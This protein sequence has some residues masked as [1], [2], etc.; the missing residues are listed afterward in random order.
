M[1]TTVYT[2]EQIKKLDQ[3]NIPS[4]IA[5][6]PDGNRRWA[7]KNQTSTYEGH[8][9][10]GDILMEA[11]KAAKEL[12]VKTLTFY[13]F[14]T[15]N[16]TRS[17]LEVAAF[18]RLLGEYLKGQQESMIA[19]GI[20]LHTIGDPSRIPQHLKDIVESTKKTTETSS[21]FN[22]VLALNYGGRD[23]IRR[24]FHS[25]LDDYDKEKVKREEITESLISRYI[26]TNAWGD[27]ELLIR[28][29][30]EMR[31]SNFLLWQISYAEIYVAP[32]LWPEFTPELLLEA[33]LSYQQ[34]ERRLGG[35]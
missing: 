30:G 10:G 7:K 8:R 34:R 19:Q 26:D 5:I 1:T 2:A 27:P 11:V 17:S 18:M 33:V 28:A 6:I 29:G 21:Q 25:I 15:E 20:R 3:S 23:E 13:T 22:L 14:S 35:A 9:K 31:I 12:G 24:A 32:V 4:H 16:W